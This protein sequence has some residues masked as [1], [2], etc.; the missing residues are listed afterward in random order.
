MA[1]IT[2][3]GGAYAFVLSGDGSWDEEIKII[4]RNGTSSE[5]FFGYAV[6]LYDSRSLIGVHFR[7]GRSDASGLAYIFHRVNGV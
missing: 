4:P 7:N 3:G 5:Y 1:K 6:A 2:G